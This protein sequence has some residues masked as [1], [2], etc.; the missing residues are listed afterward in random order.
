MLKK[1]PHTYVIV[2]YLIIAAAILTW[3][4]PGG[5][6]VKTSTTE[7]GI[8]QEQMVFHYVENQPQTWQ[9][10]AAIFKGFVE[11]ADIIILILLIGGSFWIMNDSKAIDVGIFSFL[12]MSQK[13]EKFKFIRFLG[14]NN[15]I[16]TLVMLMFSLFGAVFGMSEETIAFIVILVP[17]AIKMGYDSIV[18]VSMVFVGA[19]LGFAGAILNPFTIGIAQG[20]AGLPLYSGLEYRV[21]C[22][23][24][25]NAFG[26]FWVL[27]Y[28]AKIKKNPNKSPVYEIDNYWR[29]KNAVD[30]EQVSYFTPKAAWIVYIVT[31][32]GLLL[33]SF[34]WTDG[35]I[36]ALQSHISLGTIK[37]SLYAVP[38]LSILFI[39][40]SP[41]ALKKSVHFFILNLLMFTILFLIVGVMG[42]G[43]YMLEIA[44][45]FFVM[46]LLS[47]FAMNR[48]SSQ[49]TKLFLEGNKDIYSAALIV[50]LANGILI[51]LREGHVIDT[52]LYKA[53]GSLSGLG[54]TGTV[55][56]MYV[57]QT[58]INVVIPS[59]SAKAAITMP[60]MAPFSDLIGLSKQATVMAFQF[61][62]GFTN[63]ITPTSGVL[64]GVLSV[65]RIPYDKWVKWITPMMIILI[66]LG[67]ILLIPTATMSLNGF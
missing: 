61:G 9:V 67:F 13:L 28:A 29:Q 22:W 1:I 50:G 56:L 34:K 58:L 64:L 37:I 59:G 46:G 12:R 52:L 31:A 21:L 47:G 27:R 11:R 14:I 20:I 17:L 49:I 2:F 18:G 44:T 19:G 60:V 6:Y 7:N 42:H 55:G 36:H 63:M 40:S 43:W 35:S 25:I 24:V 3:F 23:V 57:I 45:L 26:I 8:E 15:I 4:V 62:D 54:E 30:P 38:A 10:F 33:F 65:A 66:L 53:S 41:F 32:I 16:I 48:N 51:I 5:E 39:I